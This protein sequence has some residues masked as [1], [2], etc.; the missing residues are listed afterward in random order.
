MRAAAEADAEQL[1]AEA[2]ADLP[3]A[4]MAEMQHRQR[5]QTRRRLIVVRAVAVLVPQQ[6]ATEPV[7]LVPTASSSFDT[8]AMP[9]QQS[10]MTEP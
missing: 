7:E 3:L 2:L 9:F 6:V 4:A 8:Q 5:V 1:P 10:R